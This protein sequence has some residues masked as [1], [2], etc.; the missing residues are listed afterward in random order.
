[1]STGCY[2]EE[3]ESTDYFKFDSKTLFFISDK[4]FAGL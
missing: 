2:F 1:M 3:Y 4:R